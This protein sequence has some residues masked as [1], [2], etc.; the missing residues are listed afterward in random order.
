MVTTFEP[1]GEAPGAKSSRLTWELTPAGESTKLTLVHDELDPGDP[2]AQQTRVGWVIL[3]SALK[4]WLETAQR[5]EIGTGK[6]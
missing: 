3:F 5:L 4:T 1:Q 2:V 6:N